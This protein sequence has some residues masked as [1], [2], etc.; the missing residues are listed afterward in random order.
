VT[1]T[2]SKAVAANKMTF[3]S[4]GRDMS[5]LSIRADDIERWHTCRKPCREETKD[6][7]NLEK[8]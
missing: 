3:Q 4:I 5:V 8:L 2:E 6:A 1:P 7:L